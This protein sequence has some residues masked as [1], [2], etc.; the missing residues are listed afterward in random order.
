MQLLPVM[1]L[2]TQYAFNTKSFIS[3]TIFLASTYTFTTHIIENLA[4]LLLILVNQI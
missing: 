1:L 4:F 2:M 3:K